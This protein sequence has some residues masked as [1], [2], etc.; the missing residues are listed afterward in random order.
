MLDASSVQILETLEHLQCVNHDDFLVFDSTVL[1]QVCETAAF[2]VL[3]ED[4][5]SVPMNLKAD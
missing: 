5:N 1:E 2:A 3:F 4:I